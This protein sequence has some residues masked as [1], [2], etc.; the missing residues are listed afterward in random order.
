MNMQILLAPLLT[1]NHLSL[2]HNDDLQSKRVL[3]STFTP[4]NDILLVL[5]DLEFLI[6][7]KHGV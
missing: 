5:S 4:D 3:I 6:F 1:E 2:L 7:D